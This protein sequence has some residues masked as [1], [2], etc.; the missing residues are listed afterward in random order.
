METYVYL[1]E[2]PIYQNKYILRFHADKLPFPNG[3]NGSYSVLPA[4]LLNLSY[5]DYLRYAR[6]RLGAELVGKNNQY[7]IPYFDITPETKMLV[8]VLNKRLEIILFENEHP[9]EIQTNSEGELVK[10]P[11]NHEDNA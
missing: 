4:R 1:D 3:T 10:V 9:Y 7:V 8:K 2:S 11:F 5:T 6:D